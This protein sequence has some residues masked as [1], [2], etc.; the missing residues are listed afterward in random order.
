MKTKPGVRAAL[1]ALLLSGVANA[2]P[3]ELMHVHGLA[4]SPDGKQLTI[5]SHH[6]LAVYSGGRWARAF[7]AAHDYMGYSATRKAIYSSGHPAP[8]SKLVNPFGLIKS[9]DGGRT[10]QKL[11]L[12]GE[13]DF[14]LLATSFGSPAIYVFNGQPNSR[15]SAAGL[16]STV[17]DGKSW[18]RA[19]AQ[20]LG[21]SPTAIAVHPANGKTVAVAT[22]NGL[23]L[24]NDG[25]A[26]F[27][28][29][30]QGAQV[31]SAMFSLD[32]KS[33]WFGS[34]RKAA[35][36]TRLDLQSRKSESLP[37]PIQG[38]DAVSYIAQ[39]PAKQQEW[40]I[41]T[42]KRNVYLSADAGKSWKQIAKEGKT[43]E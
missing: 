20:G 31:L 33:L 39:N 17:D 24:S 14:H 3:L 5:P 10:W 21:E 1:L 23:Y 41:A 19:T 42:F 4:Y 13:S 32:G 9:S 34:F 18:Q 6:G 2:A 36:L 12:E 40:A 28:P 37:L 22:A 29:L 27:T 43:L 35:E 26:R 16:Y 8:D 7:G 30:L 38:Q 25:G 15:M 11:G